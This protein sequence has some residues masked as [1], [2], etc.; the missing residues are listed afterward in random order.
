[1]NNQKSLSIKL[2]LNEVLSLSE[3]S[4]KLLVKPEA[5]EAILTLLA[6]QKAVGQALE[7]VKNAIMESGHDLMPGFSGIKGE[8]ISVMARSYGARYRISGKVDPNFFYT[9]TKIYPNTKQI[10]IFEKNTGKLPEGIINSRQVRHVSFK[11]NED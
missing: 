11:T 6:M 9:T 1:M 3:D 10:D 5:E 8:K 2:N 7:S 4:K